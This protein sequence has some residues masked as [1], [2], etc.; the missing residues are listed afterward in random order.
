MHKATKSVIILSPVCVHLCRG[1]AWDY[2]PAR[3][4][5]LRLCDTYSRGRAPLVPLWEVVQCRMK[6]SVQNVHSHIFSL[7]ISPR[8]ALRARESTPYVTPYLESTT[9]YCTL[10]A[11]APSDIRIS[12]FPFARC[13]TRRSPRLLAKIARIQTP[14]EI[15]N[16]LIS[17]CICIDER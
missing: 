14:R 2:F 1:R 5:V 13:Y 15:G 16:A 3:L 17:H 4:F 11:I 12:G 7:L 9:L 8:Y 6:S 10:T